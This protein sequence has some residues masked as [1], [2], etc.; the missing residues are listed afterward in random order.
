[1]TSEHINADTYYSGV[2]LWHN[3]GRTAGFQYLLDRPTVVLN[4]VRDL[5][6]TNQTHQRVVQH[7]LTQVMTYSSAVQLRRM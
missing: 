6:D 1:V 3:A 2:T 5:L 7:N 4:T